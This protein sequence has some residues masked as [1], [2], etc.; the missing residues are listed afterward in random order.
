MWEH[1]PG[2]RRD[3]HEA[4]RY[5]RAGA[6]RGSAECMVSLGR[7]LLAG[8][9]VARDPARDLEWYREAARQGDAAARA[10]S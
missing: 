7:A 5:Y 1:G 8:D 6:A 2:T 10:G 3:P 9:A 4:L